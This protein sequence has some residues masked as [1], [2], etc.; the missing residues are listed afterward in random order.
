MEIFNNYVIRTVA[1]NT[2]SK[3]TPIVLLHGMGSGVGLWVMNLGPLAANRPIYACDLLGFGRSSRHKF[4]TDPLLAEQEFVDSIEAWRQH[5]NLEKFVL[6]GH[7]LGGFLAAAYALRHPLRVR[8][9]VLVDPWGFPDRP[10]EGT[11]LHVPAYIKVIA[12]M[13]QPFNPL[14]AV[15]VAGPWG[16]VDSILH[17]M[18]QY[19]LY[20]RN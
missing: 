5:L 6:V 7:S 2:R 16:K 20:Y 19:V 1:L 15:R 10:T 12:T 17:R 8:H 14:A 9:L 18:V 4:N 13:L 3:L 11:R